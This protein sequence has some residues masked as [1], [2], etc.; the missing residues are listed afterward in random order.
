MAQ[1]GRPANAGPRVEPAPEPPSAANVG[2]R[3][4]P[5]ELV[6]SVLELIVAVG[7]VAGTAGASVVVRGAGSHHVTASSEGLRALEELQIAEGDGPAF[8]AFDRLGGQRVE[9]SPS[10]SSW[11]NYHRAA[12][13]QGLRGA[14]A[15]PLVADGRALGALTVFWREQAAAGASDERWVHVVAHRA[16]RAIL[17]AMAV[18]VPGPAVDRPSEPEAVGR[19]E[20][21]ADHRPEPPAPQPAEGEDD[22]VVSEAKSILAARKRYSEDEAYASLRQASEQTQRPVTEVAREVVE[23]PPQMRPKST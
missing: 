10:S 14:L 2:D 6:V 23:L 21:A 19:P 15:V 16:A 20:P 1:Q 11:A 12:L 3:A 18:D 5:P 17:A 22:E 13:A 7:G 4:G 9:F 8:A